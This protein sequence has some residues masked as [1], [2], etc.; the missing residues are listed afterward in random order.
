MN[1]Y[2]IT[3]HSHEEHRAAA[4]LVADH[5][6]GMGVRVA[7]PLT[8]AAGSLTHLYA[9]QAET[10]AELDG[11]QN[12]VSTPSSHTT[13]FDVCTDLAPCE[14]INKTFGFG[15]A[16]MPQT[17]LWAFLHI[18]LTEPPQETFTL[19]EVTSSMAGASLDHGRALLVQLAS[20]D[21][22]EV[23][24]DVGAWALHPGVVSVQSFM[25]SGKNMVRSQHP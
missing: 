6:P 14:L 2:V 5:K 1:R 15:P 4:A 13:S 21:L 3:S 11:I 25:A 22:A 7:I 19:P 12:A 9:L 18:R 20:D 16:G 24:R 10:R 17:D 8:H 23:Q